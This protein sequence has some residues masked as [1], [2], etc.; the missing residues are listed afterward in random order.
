MEVPGAAQHL[1]LTELGEPGIL[2]AG[3]TDRP[4]HLIGPR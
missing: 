2:A 1:A 4:M 3:Y